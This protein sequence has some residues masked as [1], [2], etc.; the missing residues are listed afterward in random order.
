MLFASQ[1]YGRVHARLKAEPERYR[2][3]YVSMATRFTRR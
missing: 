2:F 1:L 3:H